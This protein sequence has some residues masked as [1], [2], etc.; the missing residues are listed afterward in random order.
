MVVIDGGRLRRQFLQD[1]QDP[2]ADVNAGAL[3][4]EADEPLVDWVDV[5]RWVEQ[6]K[7]EFTPTERGLL[8]IHQVQ[9]G[10]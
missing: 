8:W 6:D 5:A 3:P 7:E 10:T 4:E 9:P 2:S 1:E